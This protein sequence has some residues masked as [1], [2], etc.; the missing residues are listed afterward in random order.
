MDADMPKA[1]LFAVIAVAA[2]CATRPS[3]NSVST[4][5]A[6]ESSD[7]DDHE[8]ISPNAQSVL[9]TYSGDGNAAVPLPNWPPEN[10]NAAVLLPNWSPED[11][12]SLS[13]EN[14]SVPP[15][16]SPFQLL[17]LIEEK[18]PPFRQW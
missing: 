6:V 4:E 12:D 8:T 15:R 1:F 2:G 16:K 11:G 5:P 10:G 3:L 17:R 18:N 13:S 9:V 14:L 7:L